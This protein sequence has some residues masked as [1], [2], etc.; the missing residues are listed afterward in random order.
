MTST[1]KVFAV[2]A[3]KAGCEQDLEA[4]LRGMVTPSRSEPGNLRYDLWKDA[5]LAGR[6]VLDELYR[7]KDAAASHRNSAH[8]QHYLS[9]INDL[10]ERA[11]YVVQP[12]DVA[13][14]K[15]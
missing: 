8:F 15:V 12:V 2:L 9:L 7:E 3:A 13:G 14:Q 11:A 6:F 4:L 1:V 10:A 5:D